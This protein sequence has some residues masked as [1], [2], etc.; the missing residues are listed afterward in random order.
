MELI[1]IQTR[2]EA[3]TFTTVPAAKSVADSFPV[4]R[5]LR[6]RHLHLAWSSFDYYPYA[7][8]PGVVQQFE[9]RV[10]LFT[11]NTKQDELFFGISAS[12][13]GRSTMAFPAFSFLRSPFILPLDDPANIAF[14]SSR[15]PSLVA[16]SLMWPNGDLDPLYG[17]SAMFT[18][19][20]T[21]RAAI[22]RVDF[23]V[24]GPNGSVWTPAGNSASASCSFYVGMVS[25]L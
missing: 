7:F 21:F 4:P 22:D 14:T 23:E 15:S 20:L 9:V 17:P 19:P 16:D 13:G 12:G 5:E 18:C 10:A 1:D 8:A 6:L 2:V 25:K 3:V 11:N 24:T